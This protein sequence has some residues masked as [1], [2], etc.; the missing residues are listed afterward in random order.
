MK[1]FVALLLAL[2]LGISLSVVNADIVVDTPAESKTI[3]WQVGYYA[4]CRAYSKLKKHNFTH[5]KR[6]VRTVAVL[7]LAL[8]IG[9]ASA[10]APT[11]PAPTFKVNCIY[12]GKT[13]E[14]TYASF[15]EAKNAYYTQ[16]RHCGNMPIQLWSIAT[17]VPVLVCE[18]NWNEKIQAKQNALLFLEEARKLLKNNK[19]KENQITGVLKLRVSDIKNYVRAYNI[20]KLVELDGIAE[21]SALRIIRALRPICS[22]TTEIQSYN[23]K[24][25]TRVKL[26]PEKY[27]TVDR[28]T[29]GVS[30]VEAKALSLGGDDAIIHVVSKIDETNVEEKA[31]VELLL[32]WWHGVTHDALVINGKRYVPLGHGTNAA[33]ECKTLWVLEEIY[34][35]MKKW[36]LKDTNPGWKTTVAKKFAYLVGLQAVTR[37]SVGIPFMPEDFVI[38]PSVFSEVKG[39]MDKEF[40]DGHE[41]SFENNT[42][43]V[44]RSDGYFII[45]IPEYMY[46]EYINRLIQSG[47]DPEEAEEHLRAF[48][49]D[50]SI[51]SYRCNGAALKGCGDKHIE[52]HKFLWANNI[53]KTPD[54]RDLRTV[55]VFCDETVLKTTIGP[56]GAYRTF[57]DW[58]NS[59]RSEMALGICVKGH[60]KKTKD[61][62]YQVIQSLCE[63]SGETIRK[64]AKSTI[65]RVNNAHTV[66]G[67]SKLLGRERGHILRVFPEL[68]NERNIKEAIQTKLKGLIDDA[69][70]GKLLHCSNYA[71]ITPDPIYV[72]QGWF[73]LEKTGCLEAGE[74]HV[75]G[76][77]YGKM[78]FWRSPVMHPNSVRVYQNV[79]IKQEYK[80]YFKSEQFVIIMNSKDD[81]SLAAAADWDGD[82][83]SVSTYEPLI[84]AIE[85]TLAIWDKLVIWETPKTIKECVDRVKELDY[86]EGLTKTNELGLTVYGLNALLNRVLKVKDEETGETYT[87]IIDISHRGVNF[88]VFAG[89]VLVDASK[90]GGA[91]IEE[92]DESKI[93]A[94]MVQPWAKTYRD[95]AEAKMNWRVFVDKTNHFFETKAD[96]EAFMKKNAKDNPQG[97]FDYLGELANIKTK[98]P[99]HMAGTLNKL[100]ALYGTYIDRSINV[101]DVPEN[102]FDFHKLMFK[103]EDETR[104]G[105]IGL[106]SEGK[107]AYVQIG[108]MKIRPDE[109][110]FNR[111]AKRYEADRAIWNSDS[112][113]KDKDDTS[114][115]DEWRIYAL[116]EIEKYANAYGKEL[117][118]AY[119]V[120]TWQMFKYI[121]KQYARMDH[122]MD[123]TRDNL[124]RA[125]WLIFGGMAEAAAMRFEK[126]E[127]KK[128][129]KEE[130]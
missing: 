121:D 17:K 88:K 103:P 58:A 50:H 54:G 83:G 107:A 13:Y 47:M 127:E 93:S 44:N 129:E 119:D 76:V 124:W 31:A 42:E 60:A 16:K 123:Y 117:E 70:G 53:A 87:V 57:Q 11:A 90:H 110:L 78:G 120:I 98:D 80:K 77:K 73:G 7:P 18:S 26:S 130:E 65:D 100:Y 62:S 105:I 41:E 9:V 55:S 63:A 40:L 37:K 79:A 22:L 19:I 45:D 66:E 24:Q 109:G 38:L 95:A 94:D 61:V 116:A 43:N 2:I 14:K 115:E 49:N 104:R 5:V 118:D 46:P 33:K 122:S 97:P 51:N 85:E 28:I 99:R 112:S 21:K 12:K 71:F 23:S 82:H 25:F 81:V 59:V 72:L 68:A 84:E 102:K 114:F 67:A 125:Y 128:E 113:K 36:L 111:L 48:V 39:K 92:P 89:N 86:I 101:Y 35:E 108:T 10:E 52:A 56:D 20:D 75:Y 34:A 30:P 69:F 126:A 32:D 8:F 15:E 74:A 3:E 91:E 27:Y 106:I 4:R 1:K 6:F 29:K 64:M 96:A